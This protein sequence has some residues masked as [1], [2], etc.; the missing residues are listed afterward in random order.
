MCG[1]YLR[2]SDKQQ[3]AEYF[4]VQANLDELVLSDWNYNVAPATFQPVVRLDHER[5]ERELVLMRW[6]LVPAFADSPRDFGYNTINAKA[7]TLATSRM[8]RGPLERRR[9]LIPADGFYEWKVQPNVPAVA[10]PVGLFGEVIPKREKKPAVVKQPYCFTLRTGS[11]FA[12]AGLWDRWH[13]PAG[14]TATLETFTII[15]TE[16]NELTAQVHTRMPAILEPKDYAEWLAAEKGV[17]APV[18]LLRPLPA[19]RM[20]MQKA[21]S[22]VG[23]IRNN[24]PEMLEAS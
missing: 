2:R 19:E 5:G 8:Y 7:E 10:E 18:E 4:H 23:N 22:A 21:N 13:N 6:G 11:P 12:F 9:C 17:R 20:Q 3:L 24:G 14:D 1:R 15:T 16:P